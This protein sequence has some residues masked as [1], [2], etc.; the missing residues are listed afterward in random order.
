MLRFRETKK[1]KKNYA[2]KKPIKVWDVHVD[3]LAILSISSDI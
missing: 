3:N 1:A 2:T